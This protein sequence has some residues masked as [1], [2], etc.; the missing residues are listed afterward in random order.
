MVALGSANRELEHAVS[1][2]PA[3]IRA[4]AGYG[5]ATAPEVRQALDDFQPA[6]PGMRCDTYLLRTDPD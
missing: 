5:L 1:T 6:A 4:T 2:A 3:D